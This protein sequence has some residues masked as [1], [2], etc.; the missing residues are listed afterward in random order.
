M[1]RPRTHST[2][3][4]P[5]VHCVTVRGKPYYYLQKNRGTAQASARIRLPNDPRTPE[6][7]D[8]YRR[9]MQLPAPVV[10]ADSFEHVI[11]LYL[12]SPDF[13]ELA[14]ATR[15]GYER[16]L[17][18][19]REKWGALEVKGLEPKHV[20]ALRDSYQAN[21]ATA[22]AIVSTLSAMMCWAIPRGYRSEN[23][24]RHIKKLKTGDGWG[25]WPWEMIELVEKHAPP[26]MWH[27]AALALYTGQ[28]E[29]DVLAMTWTQARG[30]VI[31]LRQQKTGRQLVI[32]AHQKLLAVLAAIPRHTV[33][34]LSSSRREPW[35]PGGFRS[36]WLAN[37]KGPLAPIREAGLVFHGLRKS[38]V[39]T[40]LEA[41]CTD[42]ETAAITG[43]SRQMIEHYSRQVNQKKL[44]AA[45]ILKWEQSRN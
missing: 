15:S 20:L 7:W 40:L 12:D 27:A 3:L 25:P 5:H 38:A 39:V 14:D 29:S 35:T 9:H 21:P 24:A 37:L 18:I 43:Q 41:G 26:W 17:R 16:Y 44:A 13:K 11:K 1:A 6:W 30:G 8:E 45:A 2:K 42:A 23:P 10:K 34:I 36:S 28:R 22:N 33:Q 4:P 32:P 31:E 19:I